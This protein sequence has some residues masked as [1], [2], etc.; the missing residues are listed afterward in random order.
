MKRNELEILLEK[1]PGFEDAKRDLEQYPTP[2][3]IASHL[4]WSALM[5]GDLSGK[6][7]VDLGCGT[8]RLLIGAA[9]LGAK[10]AVG[11]DV[12]IS[13]IKSVKKTL[14][15]MHVCNVELLQAQVPNLPLRRADTVIQNPPFGTWK[16]GADL[17]FLRAA[18]D[19]STNV[20]SIHKYNIKSRR[21][22]VEEAE[23]RGFILESAE[24]KTMYIPQMFEDHRRRIYRFKVEM[25][26]FRRRCEKG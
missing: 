22:I 9:V 16:R 2:S 18:F 5:H 7:V 14:R 25:Y 1:I 10:I 21:V 4:L 3:P 13:A 12:D 24:L 15:D 19:I 11:V 26:T 6:I 17:E 8:G 20:Y 23:K